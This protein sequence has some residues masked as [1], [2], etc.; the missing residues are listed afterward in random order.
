MGEILEALRRAEKERERREAPRVVHRAPEPSFPPLPRRTPESRTEVEATEPQLEARAKDSE[1]AL[2]DARQRVEISRL[3][4][5]P[6]IARAVLLEES[7]GVV[8]ESYRHFAVT[9]RAR[10]AERGA[11]SV[12]VT[13]AVGAEGKTTTACNLAFASASVAGEGRI[14]LVD[15]DL[16]HPSVAPALGLVPR[17][18][19]DSV[20]V[21]GA[22]LD[23]ACMVPNVEGLDLYLLRRSLPRAHEI[24]AGPALG[25]LVRDL[26][27]LYDLVIFDTPPSLLVPDV[28]LVLRHAGSYVTVVRTGVTR[29]SALRAM[30]KQLPREKFLGPFVNEAQRTRHIVDYAYYHE[31]ESDDDE[32]QRRR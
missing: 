20:L 4:S 1:P 10:I 12:V 15:L 31:M 11:R 16:R 30:L 25:T 3:K 8:A 13:S 23:A 29:L 17:T 26:E 32:K 22:S 7:G 27:R 24:L 19:I 6:W 21:G 2:R 18:G 5:H 14:A 28:S 9:M